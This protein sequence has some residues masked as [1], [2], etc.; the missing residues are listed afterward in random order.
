MHL[1]PTVEGKEK[2]GDAPRPARR[3][4]LDPLPYEQA[5]DEGR[6]DGRKKHY[7]TP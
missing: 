2:S 5:T 1:Q 3:Y 4:A 7:S 6:D